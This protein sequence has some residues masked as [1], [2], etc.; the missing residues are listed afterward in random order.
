LEYSGLASVI[1]STAI[2]PMAHALSALGG[3]GSRG[4]IAQFPF[5]EWRSSAWRHTLEQNQKW[6]AESESLAHRALAMSD[7]GHTTCLPKRRK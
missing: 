1:H 5:N 3:I 6:T 4:W 2:S 7:P